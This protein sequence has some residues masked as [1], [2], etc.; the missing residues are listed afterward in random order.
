[1]GRSLVATGPAA[2]H[3][4]FSVAEPYSWARHSERK[5]IPAFR[6]RALSHSSLL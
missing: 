3:W 5:L 2:R 4:I 6:D 1:M